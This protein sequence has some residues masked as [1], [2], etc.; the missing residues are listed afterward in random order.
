MASDPHRP[1]PGAPL[2]LFLSYSRPD[3]TVAER[4]ADRLQHA[5]HIVWWDALIEGGAKFASSIREALDAADVVIVLWSL[6]SVDSD[7]VRDEAAQG[8]DRHRLVP[9]S[10]DGSL[11]PLGFRQYQVIDLAGWNGAANAPELA[12]ILRAV[13]LAAGQVVGPTPVPAAH[14]GPRSSRRQL[15]IGAGAGTI[16]AGGGALVAWREMGT[17]APV[18]A[19]QGI[20]VLPFKNLSGDPRQDYFAAGLT[21][22][23]RAALAAN[24]ALQVIAATSSNV[25][26]DAAGGAIKIARDLGVAYLL[27][28]SVQRSGDVV[29][30]AASLTDGKT[31]FTRWSRSI[32]RRMT[33]IFAVQNEIARTVSEALQVRI[34][35]DKPAPGGTRN[36]DAYENFLRGRALYNQAKDEETD[37]AAL[38]HFDLA[39]AADN[40]FAMAYAA[41]SRS[42]AS[43]A[44]EY[45]KGEELKPLYAASIAS[46]RRALEL[47]PT[48]AEA[49]LA[50]GY[51][52]FTGSLDVAGARPFYDRAFALG[53]GNAD[54]IL[55]FAL[56]CSRAGR[57][58]EARSAISRAIA[59]DP[60]NPRAHR[61]A[62]SIDYAARRYEE[63]LAPLARAVQLNPGI[64][65]AR[66][67]R[68]NCLLQLGRID[69]ARAAFAAEP[70]AMFRLTGLAIVEHRRGDD[71][72]ANK[73]LA[74]LV[75]EVGDSALYQ[76]AEVLAQLGRPL[77]AIAALERARAIG[78]S[79]LIY[80]TTDPLLDPIRK[81]P[82]FT[83]LVRALNLD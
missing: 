5:G 42:L 51:V 69:E 30:I 12:A 20:A 33:D 36:V 9:L 83:K 40:R 18:A 61:A 72:A 73:H 16:V 25:A 63:A 14:S 54:I 67:H 11:P 3:R 81:Q 19:A 28:G 39:I 2:T 7:W 60:L 31:G 41:R 8:R 80:L 44:A 68:G 45:A 17:P 37:R 1:A 13:A 4:L 76:Q 70:S 64:S 78:D 74:E 29:R 34:A 22:E 49:N 82:G 23:V 59:L 62:G 79:G 77:D 27:D 52:L 38:A 48:L 32:D 35:T 46:A 47:A 71:A 57:A 26:R 53:R 65:N 50:L 55:L 15:L 58:D 24:D 10:I 43:I 6:S 75:D 21:E 66:S 56:Y